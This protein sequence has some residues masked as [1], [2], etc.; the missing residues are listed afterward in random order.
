[1]NINPIA[2]L[3]EQLQKLINEH[4]SAVILRD[5]LALFKDQVAILENK[6]VALGKKVST[7][8]KDKL[9]LQSKVSALESE[10]N[11][12]QNPQHDKRE[13][14][15][16]KVKILVFLVTQQRDISAV[17]LASAI[18]ENVQV[19]EFHL[20]DLKTLDM[21]YDLLTSGSPTTWKLHHEGRR[22]LIEHKL[23]S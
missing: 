16:V 12:L 1:M 3:S 13:L 9:A 22:Y 7:L 8:E 10:L 2:A 5:H 19:V 6:A 23:L 21:V 14:D 15:A 17:R 20:T 11:Q 18:S 4:G